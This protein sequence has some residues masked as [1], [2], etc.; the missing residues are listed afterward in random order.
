MDTVRMMVIV[1][2]CV[3]NGMLVW[4]LSCDLRG[5]GVCR[6]GTRDVDWPVGRTTSGRTCSV[7]RCC[8]YTCVELPWVVRQLVP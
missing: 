4:L 1:G 7:V 5:T 2:A 3:C 6:C 8:M